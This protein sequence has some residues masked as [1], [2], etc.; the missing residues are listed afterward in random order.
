M[1]FEN[2]YNLQIDIDSNV[3]LEI[4]EILRE[5]PKK[6][7]NS[8][9]IGINIEYDWI[10]QLQQGELSFNSVGFKQIIKGAPILLDRQFIGFEERGGVLLT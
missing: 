3:G 6:P 2:V 1:V 10:I 8:D 5:N 9:H 7:K 4:D